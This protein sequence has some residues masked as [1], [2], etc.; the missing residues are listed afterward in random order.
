MIYIID[1]TRAKSQAKM[2]GKRHF[3]QVSVA[4]RFRGFV[5]DELELQ[6]FL[7]TLVN[8]ADVGFN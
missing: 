1:I 6:G 7:M 4:G 5:V 2:S 8:S 3:W